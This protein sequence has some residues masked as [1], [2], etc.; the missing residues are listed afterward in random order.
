MTVVLLKKTL[1]LTGEVELPTSKSISNRLLIIDALT[2]NRCVLKNLSEAGDTQLLQY[3]LKTS[4]RIIDLENAGTTMR[5]L[6]AYHAIKNE[7][8][9]VLTG[10]PRMRER[11][12]GPLVEALKEIGCSVECPERQGY[13]PVH[14]HKIE[15]FSQKKNTITITGDKS[16]QY[17]SALLLAAP[18]L[19]K[20]LEIIVK[21]T[22]VSKSYTD[23][24][25]ALMR[26]FGVPV[27]VKGNTYKIPPGDYTPQIW[28]AESDW[29]SASYFYGMA[30]LAEKAKIFLKGLQKSSLQGDRVVAEI[31]RKFGVETSFVANGAEIVKTDVPA[32]DYLEY[33]F[34]SCPDLAQTIAF[35]CA[36]TG[37]TLKMKGIST[38]RLKETDRVLALKQELKK[39]GVILT[40][41][42]ENTLLLERSPF[43][44]NIVL[45]AMIETYEDHRMAMTA[46]MFAVRS[47]VR[48]ENPEA[49]KKSFPRFWDRISGIGI[50]VK[51][52]G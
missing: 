42:N 18:L 22:V 41:L 17:A 26:E 27:R 9:K 44:K 12:I 38:L 31:M 30:A 23:M 7:A 34:S 40:E 37:T 51:E 25:V 32:P 15:Y 6:T 29:S 20:G 36:G 21:G 48:I 13:P 24:T 14:I 43:Y 8:D 50:K 28:S 3:A 11:P 52:G 5:F 2:G 4:D 1:S 39:M 35:V 45:N 47:D 46:A 49:V 10:S 33:D 16:S 19:P